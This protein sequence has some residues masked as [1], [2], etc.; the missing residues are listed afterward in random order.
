[1]INPNRTYQD[2]Q[3]GII[4]EIQSSNAYIDMFTVDYGPCGSY[5]GY[6]S[7]ISNFK[8]FQLGDVVKC[9][10][11]FSIT[12]DRLLIKT[13]RRVLKGRK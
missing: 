10:M 13:M 8:R 2:S 11:Q 4:T 6:V 1:M 7:D 5:H 9:G 3:V 12:Q